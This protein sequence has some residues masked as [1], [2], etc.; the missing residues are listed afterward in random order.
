MNKNLK[1]VLSYALG[2]VLALGISFS[3]AYAVGGNDSNTY[4][5]R[6]EWETKIAQIEASLDNISK[7]VN[8]NNMDFVMNGPR[9]QVGLVE[10]FENK[11]GGFNFPTVFNS[12]V[13]TGTRDDA[14][15]RMF[16]ANMMLI[17]DTW[18]GRQALRHSTPWYMAST[19]AAQYACQARFALK[20]VEPNIYLIVSLYKFYR[21]SDSP[22][23]KCDLYQVSYVDLNNQTNDY[24]S[25]KTVTVKLPRS[26]WAPWY[27]RE[28]TTFP[29]Y[30]RKS[31]RIFTGKPSDGAFP[32]YLY[33]SETNSNTSYN[34]S[35]PGTGYAT[36]TTSAS[37]F[38][39]IYEFPATACTI[40]QASTYYN[41]VNGGAW[42]VGPKNMRGRKFGNAT[43]KIALDSSTSV[44]SR[45]IAKVYSPQ[46]GCLALKSYMNGEIPIL[47][48]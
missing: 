22:Y 11:G 28:L 36:R 16:T 46:K 45:A 39:F 37:E 26:E 10:G 42:V 48:E 15:A 33:Y 9:I 5:T 30:D 3:Y 32:E 44:T 25:Q 34:L 47:N 27:S 40:R 43:D 38:T 8:A 14:A 18:D 13:R 35:N 4:V 19:N 21:G 24:A 1:K 41:P 29:N 17:Q 23:T 12:N 31:D 2:I 20:S 7:T 6:S